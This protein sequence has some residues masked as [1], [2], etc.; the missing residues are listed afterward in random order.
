M[1]DGWPQFSDAVVSYDFHKKLAY[2]YIKQSQQNVMMSFGEPL[3]WSIR[4][5]CANDTFDEQIVDY[6]AYDG[7]CGDKLMC[8]RVVVPENS[9][10]GVNTLDLS[11]SEKKLIII[12]WSANGVKGVNHYIHGSP[13]FSLEQMKEWV[14]IIAKEIG[15]KEL[16]ET[17]SLTLK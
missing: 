6:E 7:V 5:Y 4:L 16:D 8:G 13:A 3:D 15:S 17:L 10:V 9:T 14:K 2:H 1:I 12:K 11:W